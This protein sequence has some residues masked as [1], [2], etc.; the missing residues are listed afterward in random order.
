MLSDVSG[1]LCLSTLSR[2]LLVPSYVLFLRMC[3]SVSV[4]SWSL[5]FVVCLCCVRS[6][7]AAVS[8]SGSRG[9]PGVSVW[10]SPPVWAPSAGPGGQLSLGI[11]AGSWSSAG[12][13]ACRSEVGEEGED[14]ASSRGAGTRLVQ[15][16]G[17]LRDDFKTGLG[18][19]EEPLCLEVNKYICTCTC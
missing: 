19:R 17:C 10:L 3:V 15:E 11:S 1:C 9:M 5:L 7:L 14:Q 16:Q 12:L 6:V 18:G 8:Y 13:W 4:G 2:S